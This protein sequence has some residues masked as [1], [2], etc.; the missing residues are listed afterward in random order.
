[1]R[2]FLVITSL[3][4]G[5]AERLLVG[6]ADR[7]V[8]MGHEAVIAFFVGEAAVLPR[9]PRVRVI[10][11][12]MTRR[13]HSVAGAMLRLRYEI[14]HFKPDVVNSH[15]VHANLLLRTLRLSTRM[16]RLV[17]S[18][19]NTNE[20]SRL[21]MAAY[22]STDW[23]ADI[24]SNV[25]TEAV[26]AFISQK[27]VPKSRMVAIPNGIDAD[28]FLFDYA[29]RGEIRQELEIAEGIELLMAVGRLREEKDYP[30]LLRAFARVYGEGNEVCLAIVGD[31]PLRSSLEELA[32]SLGVAGAVRFLGI[33]HDIQQLLSACD[34]FVLSSAWEGFG[35]V[36]AE[37]MAC[38]RVVVAT[39]SGGVREVVG[40]TGYLVPPRDTDALARS[41]RK[42]LSMPASERAAFG[43]QAR[44]RVVDHFSL[45]ATAERYLDL[46][47]A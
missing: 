35:L 7:F 22:R 45:Q 25:S 4:M 29:A 26:N 39:D 31:G 42:A 40:D 1:M 28:A 8:T 37:A 9:D 15:L 2:I 41:L 3:G 16:P 46:Y 14:K 47:R 20:E 13:P 19:H 6:L 10:D 18:A 23:L 17:S 24:S 12:A 30:N 36:V 44:T 34:V 43:A 38:E 33:R 32:D 21:R 11:L 27:A 5:G